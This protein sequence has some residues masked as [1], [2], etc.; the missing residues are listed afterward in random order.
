MHLNS[1][2]LLFLFVC[3]FC[4]SVQWEHANVSL[5]SR[6]LFKKKTKKTFRSWEV[7]F[8]IHGDEGKTS[9]SGKL[10]LIISCTF[11]VKSSWA[12]FRVSLFFVWIHL[13]KYMQI[14]L[15][16]FSLIRVILRWNKL[17]QGSWTCFCETCIIY[18]YSCVSESSL[19]TLRHPEDEAGAGCVRMTA[20]VAADNL[21]NDKHF[22]SFPPQGI[23]HGLY[24]HRRQ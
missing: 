19:Q 2:A 4:F 17:N 7:I 16:R 21:R 9:L 12:P 8:C 11:C 18:T 24:E 20:T 14:C 22:P 5:S 1:S 6:T 13:L 3:V 10:E 15:W 23:L